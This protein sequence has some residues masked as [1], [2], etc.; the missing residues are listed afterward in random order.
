MQLRPRSSYIDAGV[1]D[2]VLPD[3]FDLDGDGDTEEPTPFDLDGQVRQFDDPKTPDTGWGQAPIVDMGAYEF[4]ALC[5]SI[6]QI[7]VRCNEAGTLTATF[8]TRLEEGRWLRASI[9]NGP[10]VQVFIGPLGR[11][12]AKWRDLPRGMYK[13]C[14]VEC[15][16]KCRAAHCD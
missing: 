10:P 7:K 2:F 4:S 14:V 1:N 6:R 11:G 15:P 9:T 12:R 3:I 16:G 8:K 5:E 13:V